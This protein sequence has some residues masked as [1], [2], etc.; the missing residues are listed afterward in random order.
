MDIVEEETSRRSAQTGIGRKRIGQKRAFTETGG[1][2]NAEEL[3]DDDAFVDANREKTSR[4]VKTCTVCWRG[5]R[6]LKR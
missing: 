1:A 3:L 5:T 6:T 4:P 2:R